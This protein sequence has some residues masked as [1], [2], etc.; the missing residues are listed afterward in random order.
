MTDRT[1]NYQLCLTIGSSGETQQGE[2]AEIA[3]STGQ[4][5]VFLTRAITLG[6]KQRSVESGYAKQFFSP[7]RD[8][9]SKHGGL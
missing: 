8:S 9:T 5:D 1:P 7:D 3:L 6:C 4:R 2:Y